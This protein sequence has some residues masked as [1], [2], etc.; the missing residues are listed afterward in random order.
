MKDIFTDMQARIGSSYLSDL[1]YHKRIVWNELKRLP[2]A[3][4]DRKQL[5][6]FSQYV[7]GISYQT[8]KPVM[9]QHN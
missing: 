3:D 6:D 4:Y 7:F 8:L 5:E 9:E 2:L 1:P